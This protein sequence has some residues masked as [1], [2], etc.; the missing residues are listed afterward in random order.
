[1]L[2]PGEFRSPGV[3]HLGDDAASLY[4]H[5]ADDNE[6]MD[7]PGARKVGTGGMGLFGKPK[8]LKNLDQ[9]LT[10]AR[11]SFGLFEK[12]PPDRKQHLLDTAPSM[13]AKA[14]ADAVGAGHAASAKEMLDQ[15][16]RQTPSGATETQWQ[17][18]LASA[19][20]ELPGS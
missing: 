20:V 4:G 8:Q 1:M 2:R 14:T 9:Q 10:A 19:L 17:T 12:L 6:G 18:A 5:A 16:S 3:S 11:I 15:A 7:L 13:I